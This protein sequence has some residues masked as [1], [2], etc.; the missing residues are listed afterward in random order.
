MRHNLGRTKD[1]SCPKHSK[2]EDGA[3]G[4]PVARFGNDPEQSECGSKEFRLHLG[5]R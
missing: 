5:C 4:E 3:E 1:P 2:F